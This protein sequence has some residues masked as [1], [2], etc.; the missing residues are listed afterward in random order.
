MNKFDELFAQ[1]NTKYTDEQVKAEVEKILAA[2]YNENNHREVWRRLLSMIELTSLNGDDTEEKLAKMTTK[3][4]DFTDEFPGLINVATICAYPALVPTIKEL[5]TAEGVGITS[6]AGGFPAAQTFLEIKVAEVAMAVS[7]GATDIDVVLSQG[8]FLSEDYQT[9]F[10]EIAEMKA[11]AGNTDFKVILEVGA[12]KT[13]EN[14]AKA[15]LLAMAAGAGYIKSST[16]KIATAATPESTW[17]MCQMIKQWYEQTGEKV[18]FKPAGG[19]STTEDAVKH[20]TLVKEILGEGWLDNH[21]MRIGASRLAN[22]LLT[23]IEGKEVK[24][25]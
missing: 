18:L 6:V 7:A 22:N 4:N 20:Y 5:L 19:V 2:H 17:I 9:C 25:F 12:L 16:G 1:Y 3:V 15:S 11:A 13:A 24:Y 14:I 21:S 8:K 23:S 10:D